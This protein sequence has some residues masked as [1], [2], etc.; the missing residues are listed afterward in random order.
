MAVPT[1]KP[2][3]MLLVRP[4]KR[5]PGVSLNQSRLGL[6][7]PRG[8]KR[9]DC[10]LKNMEMLRNG[11]PRVVITGLGAVT[12]LG[13]VKSLWEGLKAGKSG[14]RHIETIPVEHVPVKIGGE[15]RGFDPT[16]WIEPKEARR[17]GRASHFAV[18]AATM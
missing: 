11:R 8:G 15:V 4:V 17:M 18:A 1:P 10:R 16:A 13:D 2:S 3:K 14:I 6:R 9:Q 12:A 7:I 5:S